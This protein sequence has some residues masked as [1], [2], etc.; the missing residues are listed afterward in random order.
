MR[1]GVENESVLDDVVMLPTLEL[2][3]HSCYTLY[4]QWSH[5]TQRTLYKITWSVEHPSYPIRYNQK[6]IDTQNTEYK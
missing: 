4:I 1:T 3:N 6:P 5:D 2:G